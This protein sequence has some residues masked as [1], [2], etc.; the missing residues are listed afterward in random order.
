MHIFYKHKHY[1]SAY[2]HT[3][4]PSAFP[5]K[6]AKPVDGW[7]KNERLCWNQQQ[8][9]LFAFLFFIEFGI[10]NNMSEE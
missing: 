6:S 2:V 10:R 9:K 4:F 3:V 8:T 5:F 7:N 1:A